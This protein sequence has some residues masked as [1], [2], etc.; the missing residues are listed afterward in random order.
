MFVKSTIIALLA[1]SLPSAL[2]APALPVTKGGAVAA[3]A[4]SSTLDSRAPK[5]Y[6]GPWEAFPAMNTWLD[7]TSMFNANQASMLAAGST[8]NDVSRIN[9]AIQ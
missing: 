5:F 7:F 6:S 9:V 1:S 3:P 4:N 2:A 8:A